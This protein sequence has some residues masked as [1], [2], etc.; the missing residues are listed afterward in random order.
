MKKGK[1][2]TALLSVLL[3]A[4]MLVPNASAAQYP[5]NGQAEAGIPRTAAVMLIPQGDGVHR[6]YMS[7]DSQ[8]LFQPEKA[9]TRGELAQM[10]CEI[11]ADRPASAPVLYDVPWDAWYASAAQMAVGLG[12]MT[13]DNGL[14]RPDDPVT[15]AECAY[16][17]SQML[18]YDAPLLDIFADVWPGH[19]AYQAICRTAAQGLFQ[20]DSQ[21]CFRPNDGLRRCEAAA[22]FNRLLGRSPDLATLTAR[23]DLRAFPDVPRSHWA[24]GEVME[25][26]VTH[27][28]V[29]AW[30]GGETWIAAVAEGPA[31]PETPPAEA[32]GL[33]D[34]PQRI[35]G[36]LYWVVDEKFVRSCNM[37]GLYFDGN[38]WYTTGDEEL[39][40]LLNDMVDRLTDPSMTRD[41]KLRV[42]FDYVVQNYTYLARPLVSKGTTGWE[43]EYTLFFLQNGKGNCF[44]FA[45]AYCL[46]CRE[47]GLLAYT[48]VG[49]SAGS[50]HGWVEI[51]LDGVTY[52]FDPELQWYYNNR[53]TKSY[54]LFKMQPTK[55]PSGV[56]RYAW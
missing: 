26:A 30:D 4:A 29:S 35:D 36:H 19:W 16:A 20:G 55:I 33:P 5:W 32:A 38:G 25:A 15:R 18:P 51:P 50:A 12:L 46:L 43:P 34:G 14:F 45:A 56:Y 3:A 22:V 42:L 48:V 7:G 11:T 37:N 24:Y 49:T 13:G 2:G 17:L 52:M 47:L 23:A 27:Q 40:G 39:D 8:G 1:L 44:S 31:V 6:Q 9:L 41:Q 54:D 53:T 10:L 21:G 28:C